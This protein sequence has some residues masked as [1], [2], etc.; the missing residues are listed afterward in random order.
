MRVQSL[1]SKKVRNREGIVRGVFFSV[2]SSPKKN[3]RNDTDGSGPYRWDP[4]PNVWDRIRISG[5]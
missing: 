3:P 4:D 1:N 2:S 5:Y